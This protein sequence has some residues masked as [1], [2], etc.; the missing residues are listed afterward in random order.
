MGRNCLPLLNI[1]LTARRSWL[2]A[3]RAIHAA[4][5]LRTSFDH[6][7]GRTPKTENVEGETITTIA[8]GIFLP[9]LSLRLKTSCQGKIQTWERSVKGREARA[10]SQRSPSLILER[11]NVLFLG[12]R[13]PRSRLKA[14]P[15]RRDAPFIT[16]LR[17]FLSHTLIVLS[18][19]GFGRLQGEGRRVDRMREGM[20]SL[21][22]IASRNSKMPRSRGK[23]H[24]TSSNTKGIE[25][26]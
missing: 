22:R 11:V 23:V 4:I 17:S 1:S 19:G 15:G 8:P 13:A 12:F 24:C 3:Q 9:Q 26:R 14:I 2:S 16:K 10:M 25:K 5:I 18:P 20:A 21:T 7:L 6:I